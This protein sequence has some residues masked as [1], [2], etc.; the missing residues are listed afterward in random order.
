VNNQTTYSSEVRER[1]V[2]MVQEHSKEYL[3]LWATV[4]S[5][6]PRFGYVPL[7]LNEWVKRSQFG[8]DERAGVSSEEAKRLKELERENKDLC[9]ANEILRTASV[10]LPW[11]SSTA[12]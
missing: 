3:S 7:T 11:R 6:A 2:R 1:A 5:L 10:F 4:K 8:A 9:R 12:S